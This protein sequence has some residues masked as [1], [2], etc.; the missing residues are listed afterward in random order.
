MISVIMPIYNESLYVEEAIQSLL[1]QTYKDLEIIVID[2]GSNDNSLDIINMYNE[3]IKVIHHPER[4]GI[5]ISINE[6][7]AIA[8]GEYIARMDGDDICVKDRFE[9]QMNYLITYPEID[10]VGSFIDII[11]ENGKK[12]GEECFFDEHKEIYD[13]CLRTRIDL[14]HPT[15]LAK[16]EVFKN[17]RYL[18]E[19]DGAEDYEFFARIVEKYRFGNIPEKLLMYRRVDKSNN[20]AKRERQRELANLIAY[21]IADRRNV[22]DYNVMKVDL[23][24]H[25]RCFYLNY[26]EKLCNKTV[27]VCSSEYYSKWIN[28]IIE[29]IPNC[30]CICNVSDDELHQNWINEEKID[31][32]ILATEKWW[33]IK[34]KLIS[35]G[36]NSANIVYAFFCREPK[37]RG[38]Q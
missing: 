34:E 24:W 8:R 33:S 3:K 17:N 7:I 28:I 29:K 2:D 18:S 31:Y 6:G 10:I 37:S 5:S 35:N 4:R 20:T 23:D 30:A 14:Q 9:K 13:F 22:L 32:V 26:F 21:N 36:W 11:D 15:V 19:Y 16:A 25:N 27:I 1:G 12:I 38:E